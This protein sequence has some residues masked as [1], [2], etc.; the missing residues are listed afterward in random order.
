[1]ERTPEFTQLTIT[2]ADAKRLEALYYIGPGGP[3]QPDDP[4]RVLEA[5]SFE[6]IRGELRSSLIIDQ[7]DG[8]IPWKDG[9]KDL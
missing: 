1:L 5:R 3:N 9:Y 8:K 6:P 7:D 4:G 2:A